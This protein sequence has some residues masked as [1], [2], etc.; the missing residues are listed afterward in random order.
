[1]TLTEN[2]ILCKAYCI[3]RVEIAALK[4]AIDALIKKLDKTITIT[5]PPLPNTIASSTAME[6]MITQL[7]HVQP[8]IQDVLDTVCNPPGKRK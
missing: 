8:D 6:E 5:M 4:V 2:T 1:M 7:S 3:S